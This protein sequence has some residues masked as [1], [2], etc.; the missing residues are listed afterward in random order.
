MIVAFMLHAGVAAAGLGLSL[1]GEGRAR[2][3]ATSATMASEQRLH[4]DLRAWRGAE[5]GRTG[6]RISTDRMAVNRRTEI[7][8]R[9]CLGQVIRHPGCGRSRH[10]AR[11]ARSDS[12]RVTGR[13]A[14]RTALLTF[15]RRHSRGRPRG[16]P[17]APAGARF[18]TMKS[19]SLDDPL[20]ERVLVYDGAMGTQIQARELDG[21]RLRRQAP[22]A[23]T[24]TSR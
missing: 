6:G 17:G 15:V 21:R 5:D 19:R 22:K 4:D 14:G 16:A 10:A 20:R 24:T 1:L 3:A 11:R 2:R 12:G 7:E 13:L 18:P 23:A 9:E 8:A